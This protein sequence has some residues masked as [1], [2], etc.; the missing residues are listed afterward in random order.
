M[1]RAPLTRPPTGHRLQ[2]VAPA[3]LLY[4]WRPSVEVPSHLPQTK[5]PPPA[6][7]VPGHQAVPTTGH[8]GWRAEQIV[9]RLDRYESCNAVQPV[10]NAVC[11]FIWDSS[12]AAPPCNIM[13][14]KM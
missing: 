6:F 5:S 9:G 7:A 14:M 13:T 4:R 1:V 8:L 12:L 3:L 2:A 10:M 11:S